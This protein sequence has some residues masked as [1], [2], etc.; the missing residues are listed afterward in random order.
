M[1]TTCAQ[2]YPG[3][4][5]ITVK[6]ELM[7]HSPELRVTFTARTDKATPGEGCGW[8]VDEGADAGTVADQ[9]V[10]LPAVPRQK[11]VT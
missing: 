3:K 11:S 2:G 10:P 5:D 7:K 4:L 6:Y 8:Y 9:G 1:Y